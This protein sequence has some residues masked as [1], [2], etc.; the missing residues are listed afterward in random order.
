MK[1]IEHI[2]YRAGRAFHPALLLVAFLYLG[3]HA[4]QG[5]YGLLA[6]RDLESQLIRLESVA[7]EARQERLALEVRVDQLR[8]D[9]LDPELLDERARAVLGFSKRDE[10]VIY[11]PADNG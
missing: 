10:I 7:T 9:S 1:L 8:P 5:N 6:L 3:Y 2:R 11:L 4:V